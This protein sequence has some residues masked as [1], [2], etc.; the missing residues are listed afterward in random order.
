MSLAQALDEPSKASVSLREG[1]QRGALHHSS[2]RLRE[3]G[4]PS[5]QWAAFATRGP[6]RMAHLLT[7][8]ADGP[9]LTTIWL[10]TSL[11]YDGAN[12]ILIQQWCLYMKFWIQIFPQPGSM[13]P[14]GLSWCGAVSQSSHS[15]TQTWG[16][17]TDT[18]RTILYSD[19]HSVY[20]FQYYIQQ[21][22][23][24]IQYFIIK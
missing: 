17:T 14:H 3:A 9:W 18:L 20:R 1:P 12:S 13:Q 11:P 15:A 7:P 19:S 4:L 8:M 24:D 10:T 23:R 21:T 22:T 16:E 2:P 6:R 5:C